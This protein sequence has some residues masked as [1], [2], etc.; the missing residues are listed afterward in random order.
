M[1]D[2]LVQ[3]AVARQL[4]QKPGW[5]AI[6]A[7]WCVA[8]EGR[9]RASLLDLRSEG[10]P[11]GK[12]FVAPRLTQGELVG[13]RNRSHFLF[14]TLDVVLGVPLGS[15]GTDRDKEKL[16]EKH[17]FFVGLLR[18]ASQVQPRM[19][20]AY[21]ALTNPGVID[22]LLSQALG[23]KAKGSDKVALMVEGRYLVEEPGWEPWWEE[24]RLGLSSRGHAT[25]SA[26]C[27]AT[28]TVAES[29]RTHDKIRG[30]SSVGGLAMGDALVSF[31]K[32][33]FESYG[34]KQSANAPISAFAHD[35]YV[36]ALEDLISRGVI[37]GNAKVIYWY[38]ESLSDDQDPI[39]WLT[40]PEKIG[41]EQATLD[42]RKALRSLITG[43]RPSRARLPFYAAVLSG[44]SGRIMV[45]GWHESTY[46]DVLETLLRWFDDTCVISADVPEA[47]P[48]SS[49]GQFVLTLRDPKAS[50]ENKDQVPGPWVQSLWSAATTGRALPVPVI[51]RALERIRSDLL[52][53]PPRDAGKWWYPFPSARMGL[54][55]AYC[56]RNGG[57]TD[58]SIGL[59]AEHPS[60]AYQCGRLLAVL[61]SIQV[62]AIPGVN[63]GIVAR[64]Y[65]AA[66]TR[67]AGTFGRL[68]QLS[69]VHLEKI[70]SERGEGIAYV[71]QNRLTEILNHLPEFPAHLDLTDQSLFAL[72]YY[73]QKAHEAH[74][75]SA[76]AADKRSER[77][78]STPDGLDNREGA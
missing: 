12:V 64:Y 58:M 73:H 10:T 48:S 23:A 75:R 5:K 74:E 77:T 26:P 4:I 17:L 37:L 28:G 52:N 14:D 18:E 68:L 27:L 42:A 7:R 21:E 22:Q 38:S 11:Q 60:R 61:D 36:A 39:Q 31:D 67:P 47:A 76:R 55:R 56:I 72:G 19:G 30:L 45:R 15:S 8:I 32:P 44:A 46:G 34:L 25:G 1:L 78:E 70:R 20:L 49:M 13:G 53:P 40:V 16:A 54:V 6:T 57:M 43:L 69:H 35:A 66:S 2:K 29:V 33:A 62:T 71:L 50:R 3:Y 51:R 9:G 24:F 63:A 59:N 65:G 41:A